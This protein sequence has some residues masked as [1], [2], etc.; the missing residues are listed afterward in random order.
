VKKAKVIKGVGKG[1]GF[2]TISETVH[3]Y[4][5]AFINAQGHHQEGYVKKDDLIKV[6]EIPF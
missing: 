5:I 4:K 1:A 3:F 6:N 2:N